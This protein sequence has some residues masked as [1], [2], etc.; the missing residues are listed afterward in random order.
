[1][2]GSKFPA[3]KLTKEVH[4]ALTLA[5]D[6]P[7]MFQMTPK[8][9]IQVTGSAVVS[10]VMNILME[11]FVKTM[12]KDIEELSSAPAIQVDHLER[13]LVQKQKNPGPKHQA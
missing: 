7:A 1:M 2:V 5:V 12:L 4:A 8:P 13:T 9:M 3:E 6:I 10:K 11:E